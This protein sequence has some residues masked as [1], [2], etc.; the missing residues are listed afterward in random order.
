MFTNRREFLQTTAA[1][2]TMADFGLSAP[3]LF[4]DSVVGA[5]DKIVLALIGCGERG[6]GCIVN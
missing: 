2:M 6:L 5:N 1:S 4:G 3:S